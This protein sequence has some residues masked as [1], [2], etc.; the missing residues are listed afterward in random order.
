MKTLKL[1]K[2][3]TYLRPYA[4]AIE[5]RYNYALKREQELTG[6]KTLSEWANGYLYFGLHKVGSLGVEEL[7]SSGV[8]TEPSELL[9]KRKARLNLSTSQPRQRRNGYCVSGRQTLRR[10]T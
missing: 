1:I 8:T 6:G 5:G 3:D 4:E 7:R 10:Y 2:S 9:N